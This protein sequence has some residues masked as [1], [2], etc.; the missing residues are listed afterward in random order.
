MAYVPLDLTK[1][2][3]S[4]QS[5][6]AMGTS[7]RQNLAALR[8]AVVAGILVGWDMTP[9]G[10][11]AEQPATLTYAKG[12]ERVKAVLTWGSSGGADGNVTQ[13]VYSYSS[14]SGSSYDTMGTLTISY[15]TSGNVTGTAWS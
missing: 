7:T 3:A 15:D 2:D 12:T 10:G 8:D 13:A 6:S 4:T 5:I 11:T 1:P 9:S 14:N